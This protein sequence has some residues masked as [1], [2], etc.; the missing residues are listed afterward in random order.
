MPSKSIIGKRCAISAWSS[1][2]VGKPECLVRGDAVA[3]VGFLGRE[4]EQDAALVQDRQAGNRAQR[5]PLR[6]LSRA[7]RV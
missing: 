6:Q 3:D 4:E 5:L 1:T 7:I 2:S